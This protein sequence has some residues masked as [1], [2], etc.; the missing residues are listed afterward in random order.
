MEQLLP[1]DGVLIHARPSLAGTQRRRLIAEGLL[2]GTETEAVRVTALSSVGCLVS[3]AQEVSG[4]AG[5]LW[6]KLH[7]S[8]AIQVMFVGEEENMLVCRF[9]Q[10]ISQLQVKTILN[11]RSLRPHHFSYQPRCTLLSET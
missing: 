10:P 4:V 3:G 1:I 11:P 5:R 8:V 6:L 9:A 7:G 2:D